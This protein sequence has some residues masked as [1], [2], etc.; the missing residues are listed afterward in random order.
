M[1]SKMNSAP[2]GAEFILE[3]VKIYVLYTKY[4]YYIQ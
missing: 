3:N 4:M 1:F 2:S